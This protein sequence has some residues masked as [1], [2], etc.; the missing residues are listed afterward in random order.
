MAKIYHKPLED[1]QAG[2][3]AADGPG[4]QRGLKG[5]SAWPTDV[6]CTRPGGPVVGFLMPRIADAEPI[7]K[8]YGPTH[9]KETFPQ[10][11]WRFLVRAAKN[12]AAA[13]YVI[14][15]YG[16]VIGDVNEG[17][18]LVNDKAC[19]RLIDCDSFQVR[20][21]TACTTARS[22]SHSSR[23]RNSRNPE[24]SGSS[25]RRTTTT[26]GSRS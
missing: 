13:F 22:G 10:A 19:V 16:Y 20:S 3:A 14:H 9:R 26:S 23:R 18:I 25:G 11:D 24:T 21:K 6:L 1:A 17:N 15:Q 7:H 2:E 8:V 4:V 5:I 12:L